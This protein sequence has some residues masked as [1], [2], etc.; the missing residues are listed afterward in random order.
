MSR[1]RGGLVA[2]PFHQVAVAAGREDVVVDRLRAEVRAQEALRH[3]HADAVG[4]ALPEGPGRDLDPGEGVHLGVAGRA[5]PPLTELAQ[6][7]QL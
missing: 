4:E 5:R 7:L 1:Q 2:H 6:V 3:R